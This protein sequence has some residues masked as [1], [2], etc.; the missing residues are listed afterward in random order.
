MLLIVELFVPLSI[1]RLLDLR[2]SSRFLVVCLTIKTTATVSRA[3]HGFQKYWNL[4][5]Y[6]C[7]TQ[8]CISNVQK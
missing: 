6:A 1:D 3:H 7:Y 8:K 5:G 4:V 2:Q